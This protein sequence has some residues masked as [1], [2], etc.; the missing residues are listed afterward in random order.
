MVYMFLRWKTRGFTGFC[1]KTRRG[2][3]W[4]QELRMRGR[5]LEGSPR[6]HTPLTGALSRRTG[7]YSLM[8]RS[9]AGGMRAGDGESSSAPVTVW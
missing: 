4:P 7:P 6:G 9:C 2:A 3:E 1:G 5:V 8:S